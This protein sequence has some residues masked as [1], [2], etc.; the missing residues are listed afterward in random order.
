MSAHPVDGVFLRQLAHDAAQQ[1]YR[2]EMVMGGDVP[3][4]QAGLR[5]AAHLGV[6]L[7]ENPA[8][9]AGAEE[10]RAQVKAEIAA[11]A[12]VFVQ[13]MG[14]MPFVAG[15][16]VPV[17]QRKMNAQIKLGTVAEERQGMLMG[18]V[19]GHHAGGADVS[20]LMKIV[21]FLVD[22]VGQ[23]TVIRGDDQ[24]RHLAQSR[25]FAQ[26]AANSSRTRL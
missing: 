14:M 9:G 7:V 18:R 11:E 24:V 1:G 20:R 26:A 4:A 12:E 6:K 17:R 15:D 8:G 10:M 13:K 21:G 16:R 19:V 3:R 25:C 5:E 22:G 23:A 2:V